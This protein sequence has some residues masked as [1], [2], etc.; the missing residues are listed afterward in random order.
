MKA[1]SILKAVNSVTSKWEKQR[2]AEV[3]GKSRATRIRTFCRSY[4][5]TIKDVAYDVMKDAYLKASGGG[6]LPA[7][8]RQI[9]YAARPEILRRTNEP[10]LDS[11][12]F[13]QTL[14]PNYIEEYGAHDWHVVY[15][16]RGNFHE[17][18]TKKKVPLGTI[19][20]RQ[21]LR[22]VNSSGEDEHAEFDDSDRFPTCGPAN[23]YG[24]V[25][26]IEKEG[27]L[28]LLHEAKIAERYDLAI[29]S[30]KG[31]SVTAARE[32]VD[33]VCG[34][35]G[36]PLLVLHDFDK[37]GFSIVGTLQRDTRRYQFGNDIRVIDLGLRLEDVELHGL[38]SESVTYNASARKV[39]QNL[40]TN[41]ATEEEINFLCPEGS[42]EFNFRRGKIHT[43]GE[44]VELNAFASDQLIEW[45]ETKLVEQRI[46]KV[47]PEKE[48]LESAYRRALEISIVRERIRAVEEEAAKIAAKAPIPDDLRDQVEEVLDTERAT[49]WDDALMDIAS[50]EAEGL[51]NKGPKAGDS[52]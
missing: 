52:A 6:K 23:R 41:G 33:E 22:K 47:V 14:L 3:R 19:D 11:Q 25:L 18:H 5:V 24:A 9:M 10:E 28:P 42:S 12:Y 15:D 51:E 27:F 48:A 40:E 37:A 31:L 26:F 2:K 16:A 38:Q 43:W 44:R 8:A 30:T 36:I 29:M 34:Q 32:L 50:V 1:E 35:Y 49:P 13:T 39:R 45:L 7:H 4:R 20:V 21:Y 17:P 46:E